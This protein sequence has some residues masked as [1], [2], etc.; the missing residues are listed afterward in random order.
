MMKKDNSLKKYKG[1]EDYKKNSGL[2][3]PK[4]NE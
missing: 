4:L 1:F 3:L 2:I